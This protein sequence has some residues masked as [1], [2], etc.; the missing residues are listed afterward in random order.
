MH[1][2]RLIGRALDGEDPACAHRELFELFEPRIEALARRI[3]GSWFSN[4]GDDA[5]ITTF[6]RAFRRLE[7]FKGESR[8]ESWLMRICRN[9][10]LDLLRTPAMEPADPV[11]L[12]F[13]THADNEYEPSGNPS[14]EMDSH[15]PNPFESAVQREQVELIQTALKTL[16]PHEYQVAVLVMKGFGNRE[17]SIQLDKT[18]PAIERLKLRTLEQLE[19]YLRKVERISP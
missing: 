7:T 9:C 10:C 5:I 13:N 19:S 14:W 17:I 16:K 1:V 4:L 18:V 2:K 12:F 3:L 8:F 11:R 15:A 6:T